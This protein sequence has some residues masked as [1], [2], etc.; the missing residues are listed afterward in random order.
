MVG[1]AH[2]VTVWFD[3]ACPLCR[4]EI[5][6]M[7]WLDRRGRI[8]FIDVAAEP[9]ECPIDP[10]ELLARFHAR[11]GDRVHTGAAAFAAM[12]RA[13]PLLNPLGRRARWPPLLAGLERVYLGFLRIRPWLQRQVGGRPRSSA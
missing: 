13:M 11:E 12:W 7:R 4:R 1:S 10:A 9:A 5:A 2:P 3:G 6:L 8:E